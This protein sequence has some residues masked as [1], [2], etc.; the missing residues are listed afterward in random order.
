MPPTLLDI[1]RRTKT[2][3]STVSRVLAGGPTAQRISAPTRKLV[4]AAAGQM[5]Y[6]PNLLARSL[7][8]RK[9]NTVALL[10][11]EIGNVWFG[12]L[13]SLIQQRLHAHG[14]STMLC[15]SGENIAREEEYLKLLPQKGIDGLIVVPLARKKRVLLK[16]LPK[17]LPL[18]VL[19][20]PV[21]GIAASVSTDEDHMV[22]Q[23]CD[24]LERIGVRRISLVSGPRDIFS[25]ARR[26]EIAAGRFD[27]IS[28]HEGPALCETGRAA[29]AKFASLSPQAVFCTNNVLAEG[30]ISAMESFVNPPVIA[31]IDSLTMM[32]LLP[33]PIIAAVQDVKAL[34]ES[35]VNQLLPL[36]E[37]PKTRSRPTLLHAPIV[38]NRAFQ[39]RFPDAP[40]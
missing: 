4:E 26:S 20:R 33:L 36:L 9:S 2:S 35:A 30:V 39:D 24:E 37:N 31:C 1:A 23:L 27:V 25:H 14:Y 8:T 16:H 38:A 12:Q 28:D 34:A 11:S 21:P 3:V 7:R 32:R 15:N 29:Y 5:G 40:P 17:N 10:V 13:A 6:R 22:N 19:D 18:V